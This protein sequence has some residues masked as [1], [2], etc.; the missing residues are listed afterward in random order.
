VF[1]VPYTF[2]RFLNLEKFFRLGRNPLRLFL[3]SWT[4]ALGQAD[5]SR[6]SLNGVPHEDPLFFT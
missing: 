6:K 5:K 4:M 2:V 3:D 1:L